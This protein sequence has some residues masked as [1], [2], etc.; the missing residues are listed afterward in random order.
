MLADNHPVSDRP[1]S[2]V[3]KLGWSLFI[4]LSGSQVTHIFVHKLCPV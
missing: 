2:K 4:Q 1:A 3:D